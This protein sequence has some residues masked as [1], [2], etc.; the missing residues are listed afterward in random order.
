MSVQR[1]VTRSNH[2]ARWRADVHLSTGKVLTLHSEWKQSH[3]DEHAMARSSVAARAES[4]ARDAR[5]R[6]GVQ[7]ERIVITE[8]RRTVRTIEETTVSERFHSERFVSAS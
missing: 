4:E 3:W 7:T 6:F 2:T 5:D 8:E 1:E